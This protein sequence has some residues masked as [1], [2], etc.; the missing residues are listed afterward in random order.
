[1]KF[2]YT[3]GTDKIFP[4][5]GGWVEVEAQGLQEAHATFRKFFPDKTPGVLNCANFY[6]EE[7]FFR[8]GMM[9]EGNF[10]VGCYTRFTTCPKCGV[11][12]QICD[13][14]IKNPCRAAG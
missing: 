13:E 11:H 7:E 10:G 6:T 1:M 14:R 4:F 3:F 2:F 8:T 5:Y 12:Y 9:E